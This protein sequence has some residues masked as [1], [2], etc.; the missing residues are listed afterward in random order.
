VNQ[1]LPPLIIQKE[2]ALEV[3]DRLDAML[4]WVEG[5]L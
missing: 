3:I 2:E 4:S 5:K 1:I